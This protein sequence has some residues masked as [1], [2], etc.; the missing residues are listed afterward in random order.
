MT[1]KIFVNKNI[2]KNFNHS[3]FRFVF[4]TG[5]TSSYYEEIFLKSPSQEV[6][7]IANISYNGIIVSPYNKNT[8]DHYIK[9]DPGTYDIYW[10]GDKINKEQVYLHQGSVHTFVIDNSEKINFMDFVL[11]KENSIHMLWI[12]PQYFL[13]TVGE[14]LFSITCNEF[15]Y[16]QVSKLIST[17]IFNPMPK[18]IYLL[19]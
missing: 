7:V 1:S 3:N 14:I 9:I 2:Y 15:S 11:T 6:K 10:K 18:L 5:N 8:K 19:V 13:I 4:N 17:A 16:S 12:I